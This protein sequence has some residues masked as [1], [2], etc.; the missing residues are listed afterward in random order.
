MK[1][2]SI[3]YNK[4]KILK[5]LGLSI[6]LFTIFTLISLNS[7]YLSHREPTSSGRFRWVGELFYEN[8]YL[9]L[10]FCLLLNLIFLL[11][12]IDSASMLFRGKL[13]LKK[14]NGIIYKNG[15]YY[16][17]QKDI[18]KTEL[19]DSNN[20]SSILI[21]LNSLNNVINK[22][23]TNLDKFLIKG[24]LFINRNKIQIRLTFLDESKKN[25]QKIRSFITE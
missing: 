19:F 16:V 17:E 2:L 6:I 9:L 22:R 11:I 25:Y 4:F 18:N 14:N 24:F 21:Y 12:F 1:E 10:G 20:N 5:Y 8:E 7:E 15:K 23:E 13:E 3:K